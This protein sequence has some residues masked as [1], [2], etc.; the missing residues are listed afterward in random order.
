[1]TEK[2]TRMRQLKSGG[3]RRLLQAKL[4]VVGIN[5]HT[6]TQPHAN[7]HTPSV[8]GVENECIRALKP[9]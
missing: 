3:A 5:T 6:L 2:M 9:T 7:T 8:A 1:M 4:S